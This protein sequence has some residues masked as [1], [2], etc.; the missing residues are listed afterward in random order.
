MELLHLS[1]TQALL[2][3]RPVWSE[4]MLSLSDAFVSLRCGEVLVSYLLAPAAGVGAAD[5]AKVFEA[6]LLMKLA[7]L[8]Q[9]YIE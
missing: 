1:H 7:G 2:S 6:L 8:T 3:G 4:L 9:H 5:H